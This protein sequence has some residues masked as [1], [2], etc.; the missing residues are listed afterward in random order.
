MLGIAILILSTVIALAAPL[1]TS[2]DPVWDT[3]IAQDYAV[4]SWFRSL[5]GGQNLTENLE[6]ITQP[7]LSTPESLE[8]WNFTTT[9][10]SATIELRYDRVTGAEDYGCAAIYFRRAK[11]TG[12]SGEVKATLAKRFFYPY[13]GYPGIFKAWV[14]VLTEGAEYLEQISIKV[15]FRRLDENATTSYLLWNKRIDEDSE[16]WI[17]SSPPID[18]Y[19]SK[20]WIAKY[21]GDPMADPTKIVFNATTYYEY[22]VEI[23]FTDSKRGM[24]YKDIEVIVYLDDLNAKLYGDAFG[25]FGTDYRGRDIFTQLIQGARISLLVGFLSALISVVIGLLVGLFSGYLGGVVDEIVMRFTDML[26]VI[27]GLPLL[28]VLIAVFKEAFQ[29][30]TFIIIIFLLGTLGWMG[31]ARVVRSQVLT[32]RERPFVEAAKAVGAGKLHVI[33]R[34]ILPNVMSLVYVSLALSVPAAILSEA[35]LSWLGLY[36]PNVM[37][38]GRMLFDVQ[39]NHGVERWWWILPPGLSIAAVSLS[40]ILIGYA[41]DETLNPRLRVRR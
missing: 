1:L 9:T 20:V 15:F 25:L 41:L 6:V 16:Y 27:P 34:H 31:F 13:S 19:A 30:P 8:E 21:F 28:I 12:Y 23:G 11:G 35:A 37:S 14:V 18:S 17:T 33:V 26:L 32:L 4:P 40:F 36:D 10:S 5:P 3:Y 22:A 29:Q 38:W 24:L 2:Y 39:N 7:G